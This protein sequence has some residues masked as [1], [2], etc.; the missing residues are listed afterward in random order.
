MTYQFAWELLKT[1][2]TASADFLK[3]CEREN[4][5]LTQRARGMLYAFEQVL[6]AINER[7]ELINE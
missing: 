6:N 3:E 7:E 2:I 5:D 1:E 4:G